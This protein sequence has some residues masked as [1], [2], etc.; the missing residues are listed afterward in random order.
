MTDYEAPYPHCNTEVLHAPGACKFCDKY[1]DRQ[2]ARTVSNTPFSPT[3]QRWPG[4]SPEG[5][6][7]P[8]AI[9][10]VWANNPEP[11]YEEESVYD[12]PT[13]MTYN[14]YTPKAPQII[15]D[16]EVGIEFHED[17]DGDR[18]FWYLRNPEDEL[19]KA[20]WSRSRRAAARKANFWKLLAKWAWS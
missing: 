18:Y 16:W 19:V 5:Y 2:R 20:G 14:R 11:R 13:G 4:N 7:V 10:V 15:R 17:R 8:E 6:G 12:A 1:P 3:E 9:Q